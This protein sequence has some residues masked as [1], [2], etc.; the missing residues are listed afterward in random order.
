MDERKQKLAKLANQMIFEER[1][2][3]VLGCLGYFAMTL[4]TEL[5]LTENFDD[6][7]SQLLA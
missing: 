5:Y 4:E 1:F 6:S 3:L 7:H 2:R